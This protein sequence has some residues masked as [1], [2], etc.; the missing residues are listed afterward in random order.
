M[1]GGDP[2]VFP[3]E[4]GKLQA[5]YL[6]MWRFPY[7]GV[8]LRFRNTF[9]WASLR[10]THSC[11][12]LPYNKIV[13][14]SCLLVDAGESLHECQIGY[15]CSHSWW[16]PSLEILPRYFSAFPSTQFHIN[17]SNFLTIFSFLVK[18]WHLMLSNFW[19]EL[20]NF[21]YHK[22]EKKTLINTG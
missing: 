20:P 11:G 16:V 14:K 9:R 8:L 5:I 13:Y 6:R 19:K 10:R 17:S 2:P 15:L 18:I 4:E 21:R 22:L 12:N 7:L 3:L 1:S